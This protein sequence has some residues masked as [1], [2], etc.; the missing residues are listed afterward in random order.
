MPV[1]AQETERTLETKVV[2]VKKPAR[3]ATIKVAIDPVAALTAEIQQCGTACS[4]GGPDSISSGG[5][6]VLEYDCDENGNCSCF[7]AADCVAM[8]PICAEGTLGCNDQGCICE[9]G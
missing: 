1:F 6:T 5:G 2:K 7:G 3:A 8:A 9:E 4:M